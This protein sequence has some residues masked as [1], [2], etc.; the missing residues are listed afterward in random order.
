[1]KIKFCGMRRPEDISIINELKPDFIGFILAKGFKRTITYEEA[2]MLG[3]AVD[4]VIKKVGVFVNDDVE[5]IAELAN[6]RIIDMLQLHGDEDEAYIRKLRSLTATQII[7]AFK[8]KNEE[9]VKTAAASS[10]DHILLDAGTGEGKSFEWQLIK[11]LKRP[12]I[13]AGGLDA[14]NIAEAVKTL[15]PWG[16]DVSSG[17]ETN[18]C[19]DLNKMKTFLKNLPLEG[20]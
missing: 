17:I 10:A 13:L 2:E 1:M 8:I 3:R 12:Y 19:K 7:K 18:G 5:T 20:C 6:K 4:P 14:D 15:H 9:D 16:V 11:E